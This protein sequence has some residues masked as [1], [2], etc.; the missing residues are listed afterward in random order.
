MVDWFA[1]RVREK[2]L[3]SKSIFDLWLFR[4]QANFANH[5]DHAEQPVQQSQHDELVEASQESSRRCSLSR[6][7][8]VSQEG[9]APEMIQEGTVSVLEGILYIKVPKYVLTFFYHVTKQSSFDDSGMISGTV[10]N[11]CLQDQFEGIQL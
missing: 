7:L 2:G 11:A 8:T 1:P 10:Q 6:P 4:P 3:D 9:A 5:D